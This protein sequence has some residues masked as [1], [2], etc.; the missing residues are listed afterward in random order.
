MVAVWWAAWALVA[1]CVLLLVLAFVRIRPAHELT[2]QLHA[3][4]QDLDSLTEHITRM[5]TR[6]RVRKMRES[7][8]QPQQEQLAPASPAQRKS[9]I[10]QRHLAAVGRA[11]TE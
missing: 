11:A 9:L 3:V 7:R 10:R 4:A 8:E 5:E 1:S 2:E 6:A